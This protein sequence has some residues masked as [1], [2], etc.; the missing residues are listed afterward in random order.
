MCKNEGTNLFEQP[1]NKLHLTHF[2]LPL[3]ECIFL[4]TSSAALTPQ[5]ETLPQREFGAL[6]HQKVIFLQPSEFTRGPVRATMRSGAWNDHLRT[7][8]G[9]VNSE[10]VRWLHLL[11]DVYRAVEAHIQ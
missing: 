2:P 1:T 9:L 11:F 4:V 3:E 5:T 10:N 6:N 8:T 7:H